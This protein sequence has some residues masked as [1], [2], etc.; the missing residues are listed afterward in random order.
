MI[1]K[2]RSN[3]FQSI[4][5]FLL[6][7]PK[8]NNFNLNSLR[9]CFFLWKKKTIWIIPLSAKTYIWFDRIYLI[10]FHEYPNFR[11]NRCFLSYSNLLC[12]IYLLCYWIYETM[13]Y[14]VIGFIFIVANGNIYIWVFCLLSCLHK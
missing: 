5:Y 14:T 1:F 9:F 2:N 11:S 8:V 3:S 12:L 10:Y 6:F 13:F 7:L 4:L